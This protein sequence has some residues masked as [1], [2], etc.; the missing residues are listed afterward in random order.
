VCADDVKKASSQ[1]HTHRRRLQCVL[2]AGNATPVAWRAPN[3]SAERRC[4]HLI[5]PHRSAS[6][7][8]QWVV[9]RCVWRAG[10]SLAPEAPVVFGVVLRAWRA[11]KDGG[12]KVERPEPKART[13]DLD[14][15]VGRRILAADDVVSVVGP[16]A[17]RCSHL[18]PHVV[19][20][21]EVGR[22]G[23][24]ASLRSALGWAH[25]A[26]EATTTVGLNQLD[27]SAGIRLGSCRSSS[28]PSWPC[29]NLMPPPVGGSGSRR[30]AARNRRA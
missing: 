24:Q 13:Y 3:D 30:H 9:N 18:V 21:A 6:L 23:C 27:D 7:K 16:A 10:G 14:A 25:D 11:G 1:P 15:S 26:I 2:D 19:E 5:N 8:E 12:V 29:P 22:L 4:A 28:S 17:G 20:V